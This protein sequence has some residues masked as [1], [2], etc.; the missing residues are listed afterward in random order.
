M[1]VVAI[2]AMNLAVAAFALNSTPEK[3]ACSYYIATLR[4]DGDWDMVQ[5]QPLPLG[6]GPLRPPLPRLYGLISFWWPLGLSLGATGALVVAWMRRPQTLS[7]PANV[8]AH[9][10]FSRATRA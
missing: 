10:Y 6:S 8:T 4:P 5:L 2:L 9:G 1:A 3:V 7:D